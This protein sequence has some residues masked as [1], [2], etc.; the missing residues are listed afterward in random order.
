MEALFGI[1]I[2]SFI[3][4]GCFL[5]MYWGGNQIYKTILK[6]KMNRDVELRKEIDLLKKRV[7]WLER[8]LDN[9]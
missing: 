5:M 6:P 7:E 4:G 3:L 8:K 1:L 9:Q 2:V